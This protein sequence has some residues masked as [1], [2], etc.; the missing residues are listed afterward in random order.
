MIHVNK[1]MTFENPYSYNTMSLME[2]KMCWHMNDLCNLKCEYCFFD[3]FTNENPVVG[4]LSPQEIY[5]AFKKT[6]RNWHLFLGGGEPL[7]Y[8][9][10]NELINLLQQD[11]G[12]QISTNLFNKNVKSFAEEV[13][14][15]NIYVINASLHID[16]KNDTRLKKF[17]SNYHLLKSKGFEIMVSYVTHPPLFS[18][19]KE[20]FK[21]LKAEGVEQVHPLT[22]QGLFEGK[23]Y[24]E[25]YTTAQ[26]EAIR[27]L[28]LEPM[29]LLLTTNQMNFKNKAC[30][31]G[32]NYFYMETNGDVFKCATVRDSNGNLFDGTFKPENELLICPKTACMDSC[33]GITSLKEMPKLPSLKKPSLM[34]KG[35]EI[36][37]KS[38][39]G[40]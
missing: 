29:E 40:G 24:P 34:Q 18:R 17:I 9:R 33:L 22:F 21:H 39:F 38:I 31:A 10:F 14:P 4:R 16:T 12:I 32:K 8:P 13:E 36:F 5:E 19:M 28:T 37:N 25:A 3:Y 27:E 11:H 2:N 7:L 20:D 30:K 23:M 26:I 6:G 35:F 1:D 15:V